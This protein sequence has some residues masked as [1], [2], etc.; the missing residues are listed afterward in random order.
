MEKHTMI[1]E[2]IGEVI[3]S[4]VS[5]IREKQFEARNRGIYCFA[6]E[7][8]VVDA[9]LCGGL[10]RYINHSCNPNCV[11]LKCGGGS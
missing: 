3:R 4:E 11:T 8:R 6:D 1:I 10:A 2:Y 7:D 5:E 9:T